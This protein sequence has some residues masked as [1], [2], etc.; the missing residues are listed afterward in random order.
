MF[1]LSVNGSEKIC[2]IYWVCAAA[3]RRQSGDEISHVQGQRSPSKMAGTGAVAARCWS[4]CEELPHIQGQRRS[5]SKTGGGSNLHLN[6]TPSSPVML[7]GLKR[8]LCTPG[9]KDPTETETEL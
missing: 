1:A 8:T 5:P 9:P 4:D 3:A 2:I 7:R 6:Q